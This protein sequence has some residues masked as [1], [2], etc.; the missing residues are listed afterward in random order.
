MMN[1]SPKSLLLVTVQMTAILTIL[2]TGPWVARFPL[3]LLLEVLGGGIGVWALFVMRRG[4]FNIFPDVNAHGHLVNHGPYR[5]IR[6][7]MYLAVLLVTGALVGTAFTPMRLLVW[8]IL[9]V[10]IWVKMAHEE[11]LLRRHYAT[12]AIYQQ[13]T[14]RII[15]YL[16]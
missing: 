12:Y 14:K 9:C 15:P 1:Y 6:H 10:D 11:Q 16:Y 2:A 7:P 3:Y 4:S 8:A 13:Q 5:W